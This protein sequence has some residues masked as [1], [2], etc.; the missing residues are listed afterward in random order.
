MAQLKKTWSTA[1]MLVEPAVTT[2]AY[3]FRLSAG[4]PTI[5]PYSTVINGT[6]EGRNNEL[7]QR[8]DRRK[9]RSVACV[10]LAEGAL[11]QD[12]TMVESQEIQNKI[13]RIKI[14]AKKLLK[15]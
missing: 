5:A 3:T 15:K 12:R 2:A 4:W 7:I 14:K 6:T 11:Q 13:N 9:T 10:L 8:D 1:M